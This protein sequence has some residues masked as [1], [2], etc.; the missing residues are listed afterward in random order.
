MSEPADDF[1]SQNSK[2]S[3][4]RVYALLLGD[5]ELNDYRESDGMTLLFVMFTLLGVV[6]LLYVL[7]AVIGDT[8]QEAKISSWRRFGRTRIIFVAQHE[9]LEGFLRPGMDATER[10]NEWSSTRGL[11]DTAYRVG[12]W[13]VLITM[14]L[15]AMNAE[16]YLVLRAVFSDR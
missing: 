9:A 14:V 2:D 15:T 13:F 12:R 8:Y 1:C 4:L 11:L 6:I 16:V 5:F 10:T 3:Y 7:I